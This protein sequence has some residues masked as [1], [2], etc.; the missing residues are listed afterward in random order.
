MDCFV[1]DGFL[2]DFLGSGLGVLVLIKLEQT[3]HHIVI[4]Q[5]LQQ[6]VQAVVRQQRTALDC[7]MR[8]LVVVSETVRDPDHSVVSDLPVA[9]QIQR[10]QVRHLLQ[11]GG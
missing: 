11:V 4:R 1:Q 10:S 8:Q 2:N 3:Y 5:H 9:R 6:L 7:Q